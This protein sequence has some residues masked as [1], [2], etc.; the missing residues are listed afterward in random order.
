MKNKILNIIIDVVLI[1]VVF[2]ITDILMRNVLHSE[3]PLLD[4]L[5]Y[6]V[7]YGIVFGGKCLVCYGLKK[8]KDNKNSER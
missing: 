5:V 8:I 4:L 3:K 2:A 6:I 1:T 7:I